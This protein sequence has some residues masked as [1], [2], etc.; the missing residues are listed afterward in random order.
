VGEKGEKRSASSRTRK[1]HGVKVDAHDSD[2][3]RDVGEV[4]ETQRREVLT[5]KT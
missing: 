1:V 5:G 2:S 4:K 3:L